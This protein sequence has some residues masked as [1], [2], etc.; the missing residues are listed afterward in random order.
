MFGEVQRYSHSRCWHFVSFSRNIVCLAEGSAASAFGQP[1]S[2]RR[3]IITSATES[4]GATGLTERQKPKQIRWQGVQRLLWMQ[5][6]LWSLITGDSQ[7]CC[8]WNLFHDSSILYHQDGFLQLFNLHFI[9]IWNVKVSDRELNWK[10][11]AKFKISHPGQRLRKD[12]IS[13]R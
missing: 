13:C 10:T 3:T 8:N 1:V 7:L 2:C 9:S 11:T 4:E 12:Q 5:D 6:E